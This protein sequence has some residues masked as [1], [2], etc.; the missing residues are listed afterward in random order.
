MPSES[1]FPPSSL[2]PLIEDVTNRLKERKETVSVAETVSHEL[3]R[4]RPEIKEVC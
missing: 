1:S 4:T 2:K 3:T